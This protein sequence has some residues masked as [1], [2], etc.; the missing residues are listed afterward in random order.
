[1]P[2]FLAS[3]LGGLSAAAGGLAGRVMLSLGIGY[4]TYQGVDLAMTALHDRAMG[5]LGSVSNFGATTAALAGV[6][7][8][9]TCVEM[10]FA[11]YMSK[12][13]LGGLTSGTIKRMVV[14]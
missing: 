9:G 3:I 11:A 14:R 12:M 6:L 7:Q 5:Y 1:M 4:V 8:I 13:V 10:L 2:V